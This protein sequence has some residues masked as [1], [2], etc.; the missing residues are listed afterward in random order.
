MEIYGI[1][2]ITNNQLNY[3]YD[4]HYKQV[5]LK[6]KREPSEEKRNLI[7]KIEQKNLSESNNI[8]IDLQTLKQ[9]FIKLILDENSSKYLWILYSKYQ[10]E[11]NYID[12]IS[13]ILK[14]ENSIIR[15]GTNTYKMNGWMAHTLYVYQIVNDNIP[16]NKELINFNQDEENKKQIQEL[17]KLYNELQEESKFILKIFALIHDIGVIENITYHPELGSKYVEQVLKE[18]GLTSEELKRNDIK[19]SLEDLTKILKTIVKYHIL[20]TGLSTEAS[21]MHVELEY[22]DLISNIPNVQNIKNDIPKIL[23]IFAY[24]DIIAVDESLMNSEK[25]NRVKE[26][27]NFFEAITKNETPTRDKEKVAIERICDTAGKIT[28]EELKNSIDDILLR[29][30]IEKNSFIENMYNIKNMRFAGPLMKTANNVELTIRIYNEIFDIICKVEGKEVVKDYTIVFVP[31]KHENDFVEQFV[32][33]NFFEC[34]KIMQKSGEL[35]EIYKNVE[36]VRSADENGKY[37]SVRV[38]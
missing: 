18:I 26:G 16:N 30:N 29:N 36:I 11:E 35:K 19:I 33:G 2:N 17:N 8:E 37:V 24:G 9:N 27:Y 6:L 38:E 34:A 4:K 5:A 15:G 21:D 12:K 13:A 23:F 28:Y 10:D 25:F 32:N 1:K 3:N 14:K 22:K 20:I 31:D 7:R